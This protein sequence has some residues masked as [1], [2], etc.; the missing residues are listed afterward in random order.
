MLDAMDLSRDDLT[1]I[2]YIHNFHDPDSPVCL[3]L[4]QGRA[5]KLK[6]KVHELLRTITE[7]IPAALQSEQF[8]RKQA[9]IADEVKKKRDDLLRR[10]EQEVIENGF[11]VVQ[12]EYEHFTRPEI[13]PMVGGEAVP[14][15][16]LPSLL[17]QGKWPGDFRLQA[18]A[19]SSRA[20]S[21]TSSSPPATCA[22]DHRTRRW[23][24]PGPML[25]YALKESRSSSIRKVALSRRPAPTSSITCPSSPCSGRRSAAGISS[26]SGERAGRQHRSRRRRWWSRPR[27]LLQR[28]QDIERFASADGDHYTDFTA[29]A[30]A[31]S[32]RQRLWS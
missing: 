24:E 28:L 5:V 1:D 23:K 7:F 31:R 11:S 27:H 18:R 20:S 6:R 25:D 29:I 8:K 12:V 22:V 16:R 30:A 10:V 17:V 26:P 9:L 15:D 4:P 32:C 13:V 2:A 14:I 3:V 21:T 19:P